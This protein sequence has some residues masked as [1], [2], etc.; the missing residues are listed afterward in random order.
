M[1][2]N[3][4]TR[5]YDVYNF[6]HVHMKYQS[7]SNYSTHVGVIGS[8]CQHDAVHE[9]REVVVEVEDTAHEI[10]R[11]IVKTPAK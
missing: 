7:P 8:T 3:I 11:K 1:T 9:G 4:Y 2:Y 5:R 6:I 10:E